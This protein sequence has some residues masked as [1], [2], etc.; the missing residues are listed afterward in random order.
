MRVVEQFKKVQH[1]ATL[2]AWNGN[3]AGRH[4]ANLCISRRM[5][6]YAKSV[7]V[8]VMRE[9]SWFGMCFASS[10]VRSFIY[11]MR[12]CDPPR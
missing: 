11:T 2:R 6:K 4:K 7:R 10:P 3:G 5:W 1:R 12:V 9:G 8:L